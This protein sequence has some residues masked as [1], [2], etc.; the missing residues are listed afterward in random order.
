MH[1]CI[2]TGTTIVIDFCLQCLIKLLS[3]NEWVVLI[4]MWVVTVAHT[5]SPMIVLHIIQLTIDVPSTTHNYV[6][7]VSLL[8]INGMCARTAPPMIVF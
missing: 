7:L 3:K 2:Q 1:A 4:L 5:T 8:I 6:K